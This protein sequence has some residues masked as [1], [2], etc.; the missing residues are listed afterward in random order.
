MAALPSD[1]QL[2]F[3]AIADILS[4]PISNVSLR[5]IASQAGFSSPDSVSEFYG[6]SLSGGPKLLLL[7]Y[8]GKEGTVCS[9]K[10]IEVYSDNEDF[11]KATFLY[12]DSEGTTPAEA[13]YYTEG[14]LI[15]LWL[16]KEFDTKYEG[17]CKL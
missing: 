14:S 8:S 9:E 13:G 4:L 16:G 17:F 6:Y 12:S 10:Q 15:R 11:T 2:S 3:S 1:G 7:S 5:N